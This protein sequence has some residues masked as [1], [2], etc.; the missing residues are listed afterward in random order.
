MIASSGASRR[1]AIGA[2]TIGDAARSITGG[3]DGCCMDTSLN[4]VPC[5]VIR[6]DGPSH[7]T[8]QPSHTEGSQ[9]RGSTVSHRP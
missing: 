6:P 4:P 3:A 2:L 8:P 1:V 9:A 7:V 5:S